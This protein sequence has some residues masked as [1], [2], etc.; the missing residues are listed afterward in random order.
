MMEI[1]P[2]GNFV[3]AKHTRRFMRKEHYQPGLSDRNS[4][5]KWEEKGSRT[6]WEVAAKKVRSIL[7][8]PASRLPDEIRKRVLSEIKGIVV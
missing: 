7:E 8:S 2:G 1:G 6:T 3:T 5:E 4:R